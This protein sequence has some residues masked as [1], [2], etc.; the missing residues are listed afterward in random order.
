MIEN[1][2]NLESLHSNN[3]EK[4]LVKNEILIAHSYLLNMMDPN[5]T[6]ISNIKYIIERLNSNIDSSK[7]DVDDSYKMSDS[8][9]SV[10]NYL[11]DLKNKLLDVGNK[12]NSIEQ[13]PSDISNIK[14]LEESIVN[15]KEYIE[16]TRRITQVKDYSI[17]DKTSMENKYGNRKDDNL[18]DIVLNRV[19]TINI[20]LE[21]INEYMQDM[22]DSMNKSVYSDNKLYL[23][24]RYNQA[25]NK[26]YEIETIYSDFIYDILSVKKESN[27]Q[28]EITQKG[29]YIKIP[30]IVDSVSDKYKLQAK[31]EIVVK[32]ILSEDNYTIDYEII[33]WK[34]K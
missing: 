24:I 10:D 26:L 8:E 34:K 20:E 15:L 31:V 11:G 19:I 27:T 32:N 17:L 14:N 12:L 3:A 9:T 25:D 7:M 30:I 1:L 21:L 22:I 18:M 28:Y 2:L 5:K 16:I 4:K 6:S 33:S 29:A 23:H 13:N